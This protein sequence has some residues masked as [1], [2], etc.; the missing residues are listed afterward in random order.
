[1]DVGPDLWV[2]ARLVDVQNNPTEVNT[3]PPSVLVS[4]RPDAPTL[5]SIA[6][7]S[8]MLVDKCLETKRASSVIS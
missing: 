2:V 3:D 8:A 6:K 4:P 5:G 1:M 7:E